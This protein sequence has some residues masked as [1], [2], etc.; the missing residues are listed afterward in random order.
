LNTIYIE[1]AQISE[2]EKG[3]KIR[4]VLEKVGAVSDVLQYVIILIS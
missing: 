1:G 2:V 3:G 4:N